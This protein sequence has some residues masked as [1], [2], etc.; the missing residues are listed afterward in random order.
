MNYA[1]EHNI[2]PK[3]PIITYFETDTVHVQE[4]VIFSELSKIINMPVEDISFLNCTYKLKEIPDNGKKNYLVLPADKIGLFLSNET[5]V[6]ERSRENEVPN[7]P[8]ASVSSNSKVVT[9]SEWVTYK[10]RG[11]DS[12]G[13]I[14]TKYNTTITEL[15]KWNKLRS[16]TIHPGQKLKVK[17]KVT[18]TVA[19]DQVENKTEEKAAPKEEVAVETAKP[20]EEPKAKVAPSFKYHTV[21]RGDTLWSIANR[22]DGVT[23]DSIK[24]L[25]TGISANLKVGQKIKIKQI[26]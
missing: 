21:Q 1:S 11:G 4:R 6:Y 5:L 20:A 12:L 23:V 26:G 13:K 24:D 7:E 16:N 9:E 18:R 22:Y 19:D 8:V 10:V 25:N 2:Y 15:K 14:A 3:N 17:H